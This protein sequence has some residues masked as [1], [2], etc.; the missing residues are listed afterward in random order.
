MTDKSILGTPYCYSDNLGPQVRQLAAKVEELRRGGSLNSRALERLIAYFRI[1]NIY[2]SN[3]IEG[4]TLDLGETRTVIEQGLTITGK[5]LKDTL[6]AKNLSEAID[7]FVEL[8]A[9]RDRPI[10]ETDIRGIHEAVLRGINDREAGKYRDVEVQITGSAHKPPHPSIVKSQMADLAK[11]LKSLP[12]GL[13]LGTELEQAIPRAAALHAWFVHIHPFIDGNGRV[14][15]LIMNLLLMRNGYPLA[16]ITRDDRSR[17]YEALQESDEAGDLTSLMTLMMECLEESVEEWAQAAQETADREEFQRQMA[18]RL[19]RPAQQ[20]TKGDYEVWAAAMNLLKGY[21]RQTAEGIDASAQSWGGRLYF[22]DFEMP[23]LEKYKS[24]RERR[25]AKR[26]WFFRIDF[27]RLETRFRYLFFFESAGWEMKNAG[28]YVTLYIAREMP[29]NSRHYE[30][31]EDLDA[32]TVPD[33]IEVGYHAA[34]ERFMFRPH[35]G[36]IESDMI[37]NI[38]KRFFQ[39]VIERNFTA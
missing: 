28:C 35:K 6:E 20:R 39:Q 16:I 38:G 34:T 11:W 9:R 18:D 23:E 7:L 14:G 36:E 29:P 25:S 19:T 1:K 12:S 3:A 13:E 37:E 22:V 15:R 2:H 31:L 21:F 30:R 26:T 8:V 24:L 4:N 33:L 17:Y 32:T 10:L 27:R 5:P